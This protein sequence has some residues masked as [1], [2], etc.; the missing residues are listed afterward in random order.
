MNMK[1]LKTILFA[2]VAAAGLTGTANAEP[3]QPKWLVLDKFTYQK[4]VD[5]VAF[6]GIDAL[7]LTKL[8]QSKY[9][10]LDR[11]AYDTAAREQ[12]F[13]ANVELK[14]A[15][16]SMRGEVVQMLLTGKS[17]TIA[18]SVKPDRKSVV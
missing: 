11:D 15:G 9:K 2:A 12:G 4:G 14:P 7:L 1:T 17:R 5:T 3:K 10:V 6:E 8:A 16:Y 18:G 13:G